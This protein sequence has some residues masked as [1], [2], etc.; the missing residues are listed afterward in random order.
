MLAEISL[1]G[2]VQVALVSRAVDDI[3]YGGYS[4]DEYPRRIRYPTCQFEYPIFEVFGLVNQ[5]YSV[6]II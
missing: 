3:R 1:P 5:V 6:E 4:I 2:L